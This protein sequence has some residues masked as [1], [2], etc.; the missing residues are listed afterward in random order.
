MCFV[1]GN[2]CCFLLVFLW[3]SIICCCLFVEKCID[4][5]FLKVLFSI[6]FFCFY[7]VLWFSRDFSLLGCWEVFFCLCASMG[8]GGFY[9]F[10]RILR[11]CSC[12]CLF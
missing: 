3:I 7:G 4:M 10:M 2:Y 9:D 11:I 12:F 8:I 6:V 5:C 1:E